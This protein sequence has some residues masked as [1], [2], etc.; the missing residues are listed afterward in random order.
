MTRRLCWTLKVYYWKTK[1]LT[2][3]EDDG[4]TVELTH[5]IEINDA[6]HKENLEKNSQN[7]GTTPIM[8]QLAETIRYL[9][10][11][12]WFITFQINT[13]HITARQSKNNCLIHISIL[14]PSHT[15]TNVPIW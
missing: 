12:T 8:D 3:K 2:T 14:R 10:R 9:L 6:Y 1:N 11:R 15:S 5:K 7:S 4:T 13:G